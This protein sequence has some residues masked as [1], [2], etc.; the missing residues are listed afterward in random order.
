MKLPTGE[1]VQPRPQAHA[2]S[3]T[4]ADVV[5]FS[6]CPVYTRLVSEF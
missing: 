2:L 4:N 6:G 1:D 3:C 5:T